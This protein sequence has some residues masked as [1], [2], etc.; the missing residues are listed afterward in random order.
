VPLGFTGRAFA[1]KA[2]LSPD[3]VRVESDQIGQKR[4]PSACEEVGGFGSAPTPSATDRRVSIMAEAV[5]EIVR[6]REPKDGQDHLPSAFIPALHGHPGGNKL[7]YSDGLSPAA[8][9]LA[10]FQAVRGLTDR[11][12]NVD[13]RVGYEIPARLARSVKLHPRRPHAAFSCSG[14]R[15][16]TKPP[17]PTRNGFWPPSFDPSGGTGCGPGSPTPP[18]GRWRISKLRR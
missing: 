4:S 12:R 1:A 14:T 16:T 15:T 9:A 8:S 11:P 18:S 2:R 6:N 5:T 17:V 10:S 3:N 7:S 13:L